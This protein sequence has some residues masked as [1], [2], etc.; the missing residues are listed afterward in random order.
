MFVNDFGYG[1]Q[2]D[3][4][5]INVG[6]NSF[7]SMASTALTR[8]VGEPVLVQLITMD[9]DDASPAYVVVNLEDNSDEVI[10]ALEEQL[11]SGSIDEYHSNTQWLIQCLFGESAYQF[12]LDEDGDLVV[13][14]PFKDYITRVF[15]L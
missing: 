9:A 1:I 13:G 12:D 8:L 6:N 4:V 10:K 15:G 3:A 7:E 5:L 11:P 2:A 14:I